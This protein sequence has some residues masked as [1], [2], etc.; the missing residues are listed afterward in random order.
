MPPIIGCWEAADAPAKPGTG[1]AAFPLTK[2]SSPP[3]RGDYL[4][5]ASPLLLRV[6]V[7]ADSSL[8][9]FNAVAAA[10]V[11]SADLKFSDSCRL[12]DVAAPSPDFNSSYDFAAPAT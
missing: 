6:V 9:F 7:E 10:V 1:G 8:L 12:P 3:L 11:W 2:R 4:A 5:E